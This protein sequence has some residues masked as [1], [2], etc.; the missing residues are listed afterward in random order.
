M[1]IQQL[2]LDDSTFSSIYHDK[3]KYLNLKICISLCRKLQK[4]H[5]QL[6]TWIVD[7]EGTVSELEIQEVKA[8]VEEVII[9]SV[10]FIQF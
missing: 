8:E 4:Q 10:M 2:G 9:T 7:E 5:K 3:H 6:S 1:C